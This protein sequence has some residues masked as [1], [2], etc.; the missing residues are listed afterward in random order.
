M[1]QLVRK[2]VGKIRMPKCMAA[3]STVKTAVYARPV[4]TWESTRKAK[5]SK[6]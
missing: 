4:N 6:C 5:G 2:V 1:K 3:R